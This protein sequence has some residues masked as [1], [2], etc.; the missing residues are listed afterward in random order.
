[1][2]DDSGDKQ[3]RRR[4][5]R[6]L[7]RTALFVCLALIVVSLGMVLRPASPAEPP[8]SER[9]RAA[10]LAD[11]LRLRTASEQLGAGTASPAVPAL[12]TAARPALDRTVSLLT[13]QAR[14][15]L[16]PGQA[17]SPAAAATTTAATPP[18]AA[19][20]AAPVTAAGLAADLAAS[21][22]QRLADA[23]AADGGMARLL[24]AVGAAQLLQSSAVAAAA[25]APDPAAAAPDAGAAAGPA[26]PTAS[27]TA[28]SPAVGC[29]VPADPPSEAAAAGGPPVRGAA[30]LGG[31]L[32]AL[33]R[34]ELETVYG[35]QVA[36]TRL[37]GGAAKT[38]ADQ[39]A[40]HEALITAA[41]ALSRASCAPI[42]APE[43]G[44][45]LDPAFLAAPGPGLGALE[46]GSLT[47]YGDLVALSDGTTRQWAVSGL[48]EAAR[49]AALWGAE[50]GALP[51]LA[52]DPAS[53]PTLP[54]G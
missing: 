40:R 22:R 45:A 5:P 39:L 20:T 34:A 25:G 52:A 19:G 16:L 24:A 14:A 4:L 38:A 54:A 43:A 49:R 27:A 18:A 48:L 46:S 2:K 51:G 42:P 7:P 29:P 32:A 10:A 11:A 33:I 26:V 28:P 35:Y 6:H 17:A 12:A 41:E 3:R 9:V 31:A 37:D 50:P 47:A 13:T 44:Y 23:V 21:G 36:L 30:D 1:V 8:V 15:L 53:F